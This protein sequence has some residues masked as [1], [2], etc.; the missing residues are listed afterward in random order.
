MFRIALRLRQCGPGGCPPPNMDQLRQMMQRM[1][2]AGMGGP[3]GPG[4]AGGSSLQNLG[5]MPGG[6]NFGNMLSEMMKNGLTKP[7]EEGGVGMM[8]LG[9]G[10]DEH[11]RRVMKAAVKVKKNDGTV[12]KDYFEK[13]I[14]KDPNYTALPKAPKFD[15]SECTEIH[16]EGEDKKSI[17]TSEKTFKQPIQEAEVVESKTPS[18][19]S[20]R[21]AAIIQ[22]AEVVV[23]SK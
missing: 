3:G 7:P 17:D 11:G 16:L 23:E 5:G 20:R 14:D 12:H 19:P 1:G 8:A 2:G 13:V 15:D 10:K 4:G 9:L 22:E 18:R 6:A 21:S